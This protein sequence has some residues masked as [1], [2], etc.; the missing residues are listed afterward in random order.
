MKNKKVH[1][2]KGSY[3]HYVCGGGCN[4]QYATN[5][6]N[7]FDSLP[8]E[9]QCK[10]C[11]NTN[12]YKEQ[13]AKKES[14]RPLEYGEFV[15]PNKKEKQLKQDAE[16]YNLSDEHIEILRSVDYEVVEDVTD[17]RQCILIER[18]ACHGIK[19]DPCEGDKD[20]VFKQVH[21]TQESFNKSIEKEEVEEPFE[22][23][24]KMDERIE[25][26]NKKP[27]KYHK[28]YYSMLEGKS[29]TLDVYDLLD[30]LNLPCAE[31]EHTFK[32]LVRSGA[33]DKDLLQDL[34][35]AKVQLEMGIERVKRMLGE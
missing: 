35:E 12:Y 25:R 10:N 16:K 18:Y 28:R 26:I 34:E 27:S 22:V 2:M 9:Q 4:D 31:L 24:E 8:E 7:H 11:K 21:K 6:F 3:I 32:K 17:C 19:C 33:G 15:E 13:R 14:E 1:L 23:T 20:I 30:T 29:I 5:N